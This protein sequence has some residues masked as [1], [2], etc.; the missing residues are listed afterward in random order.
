[1][2]S[3]PKPRSGGKFRALAFLVAVLFNLLLLLGVA[4]YFLDDDDYRH[5]LIWSADYFL[6]S[7][8]AIDGSFSIEFAPV[9]DLNAEKVSLQAND[10]S[11]DLS[12]DK[13][14]LQQRFTS[15]LSTGTFWINKLI[16][17][18]LRVDVTATSSDEE[19]DWQQLS[20]VPVVIEETRIGKLSLTYTKGE[21]RHAIEL[22]DILV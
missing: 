11:Y 20:V 8:L 16:V 10:G 3:S 22:H 21:Q 7:R 1:M 2:F 13:L 9:I 5:A 4:L 17:G 15:Y 19:F 12:L 6:D 18:D 14:Y